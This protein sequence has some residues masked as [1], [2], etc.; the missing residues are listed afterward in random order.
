[1]CI[2]ENNWSW[3]QYHC[4][5]Y[6][7]CCNGG[8]SEGEIGSSHYNNHW[9]VMN[10]L[11]NYYFILHSAHLWTRH[12]CL[13]SLIIQ[14]CHTMIMDAAQWLWVARCAHSGFWRPQEKSA[15]CYCTSYQGTEWNMKKPMR[16]RSLETSVLI[17]SCLVCL[18]CNKKSAVCLGCTLLH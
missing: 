9:A 1:M 6:S 15:L 17:P 13:T 8:W 2:W 14:I 5:R 16:L 11:Q 12:S 18:H 4:W 7:K 10:K 3:P